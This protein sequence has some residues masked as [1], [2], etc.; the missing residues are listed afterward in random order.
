VAIHGLVVLSVAGHQ[1]TVPKKPVL[2]TRFCART[3]ERQTVTVN[4]TESLVEPKKKPDHYRVICISLYKEDLAKM[5]E[6]VTVLKERGLRGTCRS[7]LI[8]YAIEHIDLEKIVEP[9]R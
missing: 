4:T 1:P 7:S 8:R 9:L 3:N 5:D 2:T 6:L